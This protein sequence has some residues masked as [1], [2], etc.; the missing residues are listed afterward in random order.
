MQIDSKIETPRT[1]F[2]VELVFKKLNT[3]EVNYT[4]AFKK[5]DVAN[6]LSEDIIKLVLK[7]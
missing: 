6:D 4:H 5:L 7:F 1:N 3:I 2:Q